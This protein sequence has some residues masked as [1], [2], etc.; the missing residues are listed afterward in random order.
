MRRVLCVSLPLED[1]G[2]LP[3]REDMKSSPAIQ[4]L[5]SES[6]ESEKKLRYFSQEINQQVRN[7]LAVILAE[8]D[9]LRNRIAIQKSV[10][11]ILWLNRSLNYLSSG[12]KQDFKLTDFTQ[13]CLNQIEKFESEMELKKIQLDIEVESSLS[14]FADSFAVTHAFESLF[15]GVLSCLGEEE[16]KLKLCLVSHPKS[17][18]IQAYWSHSSGLLKP[19]SN[20][21]S[22]CFQ[23]ASFLFES[24]GGQVKNWQQSERKGIWELSLPVEKNTSKPSSNP[25]ALYREKRRFLR[26]GVDLECEVS[27]L[28]PP[29]TAATFGQVRVVSEGGALIALKCDNLSHLGIGNSISLKIAIPTQ[30]PLTLSEVKIVDIKRSTVEEIQIGLEFLKL[31]EKVKKILAALV[32]VHAS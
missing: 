13:V 31:D 6:F 3:I 28:S 30:D 2:F 21:S 24:H 9:D 14:T 32:Q 29:G 5:F 16:G 15:K 19:L 7:Q 4:K 17:L 23:V 8:S 26:V 18:Q 12:I 11:E 1:T 25:T 20:Y 27:L 10:K 22:L